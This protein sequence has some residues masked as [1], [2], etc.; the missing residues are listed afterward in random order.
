MSKAKAAQSTHSVTR[1]ET[2]ELAYGSE[3]CSSWPILIAVASLAVLPWLITVCRPYFMVVDFDACTYYLPWKLSSAAGLNDYGAWLWNPYIDGGRPVLA[4]PV[5]Q[6]LY[7]GQLLFFV[8]PPVLAWK[9]FVCL[10]WLLCFVGGVVFLRVQNNSWFASVSGSLLLCLSGPLLSHHWSPIWFCGLAWLPLALA[11]GHVLLHRPR[12]EQA[13]LWQFVIFFAI[14]MIVFAGAIEPLFALIYALVWRGLVV[15]FWPSETRADWGRRGFWRFV[16]ARLKVLALPALLTVLASAIQWLPSFELLSNSGR[17]SGLD[18]INPEKWNF[19]LGR[20]CEF[21]APSCFGSHA[22]RNW[23]LGY[24]TGNWTAPA[25]FLGSVY[26]GSVVLIFVVIGWLASDRRQRIFTS[27][28][29]LTLFVLSCGVNSPVYSLARAFLPGFSLFRYCEKL[30]SIVPFFL[31]PLLARGIDQFL[32]QRIPRL[33]WRGLLV[34]PCLLGLVLLG[35]YTIPRLFNVSLP[36]AFLNH[37]LRQSL[38]GLFPFVLTLR[39]LAH[40]RRGISAA[41]VSQNKLLVVVLALLDLGFAA[42][43]VVTTGPARAELEKPALWPAARPTKFG[44]PRILEGAIGKLSMLPQHAQQH[45]FSSLKGYGSARIKTRKQFDGAFSS[46]EADARLRMSGVQ[47]QTIPK[48]LKSGFYNPKQ[49]RFLPYDSSGRICWVRELQA[50]PEECYQIKNFPAQVAQS[51][52]GAVAHI[53]GGFESKL[54]DRG[55]GEIE[56]LQSSFHELKLKIRCQKAG[57][58]LIRDTYFPGWHATLNGQEIEILR[59]NVCFR[60]IY[61]PE[62]E[63]LLLMTYQPRSVLFGLVFSVLSLPGVFCLFAA[64]LWCLRRSV[65]LPRWGLS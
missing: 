22:Q 5:T 39:L 62:G 40:G 20:L 48:V 37:F 64:A 10:H 29:I 9:V 47:F 56:Q 57:W 18:P 46:F 21:L 42:P 30:I 45:G 28:G 52:S 55:A 41:R 54:A 17:S 31:A 3:S 11:A 61:V 53:P 13:P 1:S 60:M 63:Q 49:V 65:T 50:M 26:C 32:Q 16:A 44:P 6:T 19:V 12:T 23:Q 33:V 2:E 58:L 35:L 59:A 14:L 43:S 25:P 24:V 15:V 8:L 27:V 34:I 38:I 4:D 7:P 36:E 51:R